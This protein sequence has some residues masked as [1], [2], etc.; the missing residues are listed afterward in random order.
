MDTQ[1]DLDYHTSPQITGACARIWPLTVTEHM[2][3]FSAISTTH[4]AAVASS[5]GPSTIGTLDGGNCY[6]LF[7]SEHPNFYGMRW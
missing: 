3:V 4:G 2:R 6:R 5:G 1:L 7:A